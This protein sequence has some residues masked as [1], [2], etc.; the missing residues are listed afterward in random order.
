MEQQKKYSLNRF[1]YIV[2]ILVLIT[3]VV[4][5][6]MIFSLSSNQ[7]FMG[8]YMKNSAMIPTAPPIGEYSFFKKP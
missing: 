1:W 4:G 7:T 3:I 2:T 5:I 8:R 6:A